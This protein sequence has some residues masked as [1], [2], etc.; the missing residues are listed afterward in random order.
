MKAKSVANLQNQERQAKVVHMFRRAKRLMVVSAELNL[1]AGM[2]S[3][4]KAVG[5]AG[6]RQREGQSIVIDYVVAH[7]V[8]L[9][10]QT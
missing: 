6:H 3:E 2:P 10:I 4:V 9:C 5:V 7:V 8:Q 1:C